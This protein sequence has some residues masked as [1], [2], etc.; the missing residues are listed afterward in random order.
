MKILNISKK[1]LGFHLNLGFVNQQIQLFSHVLYAIKND[2]KFI[3]LD[4]INWILSWKNKNTVEHNKLFDVEFWNLMAPKYNFPLLVNNTNNYNVVNI[5]KIKWESDLFL[6]VHD[7]NSIVFSNLLKP[8]KKILD[9]I[10]INKPESYGTIHFRLEDDLKVRKISW[11]G[12][13]IIKDVY[14]QIRNDVKEIPDVVY[15]CVA[16]QDVTHEYSLNIFNNSTSPWE[17]VPLIFG[18]S[19]I[20]KKYNIEEKHYHIIGAMIDYYIAIDSTHFFS[21]RDEM[22]TFSKSINVIRQ[23]KAY[24]LWHKQKQLRS[25]RQHH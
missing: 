19:D 8:T 12:R 3:N 22:S 10:N 20:C 18:G 21:G 23:R 15:A 2:I 6:D 11:D 25:L 5:K 17:N 14:S 9:I 1:V 7:S 13:T 16:K 24:L 4:S